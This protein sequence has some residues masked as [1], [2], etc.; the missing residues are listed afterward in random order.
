[1][2]AMAATMTVDGRIG[3]R[4]NLR[5]IGA[6]ARRNLL[7]IRAD[8]ESMFDA[9]LMPV[10]FTVL[11][12]YVFGG[13]V[14]GNQKAYVQYMIPGLMA[15]MGMNTELAPAAEGGD[16]H[17][18]PEDD[19]ALVGGAV[20]AGPADA[21]AQ[22]ALALL[23][24]AAGGQHLAEPHLE[25]RYPHSPESTAAGPSARRSRP[26]RAWSA[27]T[28]SCGGSSAQMSATSASTGTGRPG[29][30]ARAASSARSLA[31]PSGMAPPSSPYAWVTPRIPYRTRPFWTT[32]QARNAAPARCRFTGGR[33]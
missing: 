21:R 23:R 22:V 8:P 9:L 31:P 24:A 15:M 17:H 10:I 29:R 25:R 4:A 11:F 16:E 27:P 7:Q 19:G 28:G 1:M 14:S 32:G 6:L 20:G 33:P 3:L 26:T 18:V 5:H 2:S 13:A 30:S 12:A